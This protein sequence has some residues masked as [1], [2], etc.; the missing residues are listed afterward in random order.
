MLLMT[1]IVKCWKS[2]NYVLFL[3]KRLL[4]DSFKSMFTSRPNKKGK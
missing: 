3:G 1:V 2:Q 4:A